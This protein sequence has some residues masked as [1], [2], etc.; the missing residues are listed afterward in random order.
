[1]KLQM[2]ISATVHQEDEE[3]DQKVVNNMSRENAVK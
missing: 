3:E 1:M 2:E